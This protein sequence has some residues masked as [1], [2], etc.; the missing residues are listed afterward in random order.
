MWDEEPRITSP[1]RRRTI[2]APISPSTD[3]L[4]RNPSFTPRAHEIEQ[5]PDAEQLVLV[6]VHGDEGRRAREREADVLDAGDA[7]HAAPAPHQPY[8]QQTPIGTATR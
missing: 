1:P 7:H 3:G 2:I 8:Q 5:L 6:P 4:I